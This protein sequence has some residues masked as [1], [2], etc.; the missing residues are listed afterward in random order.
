MVAH[1]QDAQEV[2]EADMLVADTAQEE[3]LA[4][5]MLVA[6]I[7]QEVVEHTAADIAQ[8]V[9]LVVHMLVADIGV[10]TVVVAECSQVD[11]S[12]LAHKVPLV[13]ATQNHNMLARGYR[14]R[15]IAAPLICPCYL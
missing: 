14:R 11:H 7:A 13:V 9:P 8:E 3:V 1:T 4:V 15:Q 10:H 12:L 2:V 5:H 6:D